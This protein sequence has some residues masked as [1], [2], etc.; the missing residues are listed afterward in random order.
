[1]MYKSTTDING[2]VNKITLPVRVV[3]N[4]FTISLYANS[5]YNSN[6]ITFE[7]EKTELINS[8]EHPYCFFLKTESK[9]IEICS[10]YMKKDTNFLEEWHYDFELFKNKCRVDRESDD[11]KREIKRRLKKKA[12][13]IQNQLQAKKKELVQEKLKDEEADKLATKLA[14]TADLTFTAL[15]REET[16]EAMIKEEELQKEANRKEQLEKLIKQEEEKKNRIDQT[17]KEKEM[18]T[19]LILEK[20]EHEKSINKAKQEA[21]VKLIESRKKLKLTLDKMKRKSKSEE[22]ALK[23][24]LLKVRN[25][26]ASTVASANKKG[27]EERCLAGVKDKSE[28]ILYCQAKFSSQY[29]EYLKCIDPDEFCTTCCETEFGELY[30]NMRSSCLKNICYKTNNLTK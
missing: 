21:A 25:E 23:N 28:I 11:I 8:K 3:L 17:I 27:N 20:E 29:I 12:N 1:M 10:F 26:L 9:E 24:K 2:E 6:I 22:L 30:M 16:L 14:D 15:Q 19:D 5:E 4:N 13:E 18:E 7:L